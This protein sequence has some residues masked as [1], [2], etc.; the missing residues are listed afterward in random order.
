VALE[1]EVKLRFA[2]AAEARAA[3]RMLGAAPLRSRRLQ[4]DTLLDRDDGELRAHVSVL[5]VRRDGSEALLTFKGPVLP[6][7]LKL[8][9]EIETP[10]SDADAL[11][12]I[13]QRLGYRA[14]FRY[15]KYREEY[16]LDGL[17]IAVDDTPVGTFVELEGDEVA[18]HAAA[19]KMGRGPEDY[20]LD[21]YRGLFLRYR[22]G[23]GLTGDDMVFP[24]RS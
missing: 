14:W 20:I 11:L 21:S 23:A 6:G 16:A 12:A 3:I 13:L 8:R 7:A 2:G 17:V 22:A 24:A 10:A 4:Q 18:I 1:R 15:E 9:E 19:T 5:R